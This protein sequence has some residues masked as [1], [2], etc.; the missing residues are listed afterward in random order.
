MCMIPMADTLVL[1]WFLLFH[2]KVDCSSN[3]ITAA[4]DIVFYIWG[5]IFE[6]CHYFNH[7]TILISR[8]VFHDLLPPPKL[9]S[10]ESVVLEH[11]LTIFCIPKVLYDILCLI[12]KLVPTEI[13]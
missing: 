12:P 7:R 3:V 13:L 11:L 5:Y 9:F 6:D 1:L 4:F 2:P 10:S 8:M